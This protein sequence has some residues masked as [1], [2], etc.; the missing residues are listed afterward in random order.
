M[1]DV[2]PSATT[3]PLD[4]ILYGALPPEKYISNCPL[5]SELQLISIC[6]SKFS[7]A[8]NLWGLVISNEDVFE[9]HEISIPS[10][11]LTA[12]TSTR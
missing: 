8:Y 11:V 5:A 6:F 7:D 1:F 2:K 4:I 12:F 9:E 10:T 3:P